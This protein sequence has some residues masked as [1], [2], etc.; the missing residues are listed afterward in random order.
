M[1]ETVAALVVGAAIGCVIS[2]ATGRGYGGRKGLSSKPVIGYHHI[3]GLAAPLRMMCFYAKQEFVDKTYGSDLVAKWFKSEKQDLLKKN[4]AVNLPYVIDGDV[5]VTQTNSCLLYLGAKM[6]IDKED[7]RF[8]NQQVLDQTMDLRND[9]IKVVYPF[10]G[11]DK[12]K[13]E[14]AAKKHIGEPATT[15]FTKLEGMCVGPFMCGTAIQSGDFHVFEMLDQ[16]Q[17]LCSH[18]EV[19]NVFEELPKLKALHAN[20]KALPQLKA[21]FQ[22][23]MYLN[24]PQNNPIVPAHFMGLAEGYEYPPTSSVSIA[25]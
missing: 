22:S 7:M 20:M 13:F 11:V 21:Y 9:L 6:G 4:A 16:H 12:S 23:D 2:K 24:Y 10:S 8:A 5:V 3:R 19:K 14:E 15:H 17:S 25:M 18:L 1:L